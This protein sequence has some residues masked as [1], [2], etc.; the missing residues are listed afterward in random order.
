MDPIHDKDSDTTFFLDIFGE[1]DTNVPMKSKI[2]GYEENIPSWCYSEVCEMVKY[3]GDDDHAHI[4][5]PRCNGESL[6]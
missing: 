5:C 4:V 1:K 3:L 2:C 6:Y